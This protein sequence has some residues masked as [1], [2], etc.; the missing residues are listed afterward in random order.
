MKH[1]CCQ[2]FQIKITLGCELQVK[3]TKVSRRQLDKGL[4]QSKLHNRL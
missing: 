4:E 2:E 1:L 3:K